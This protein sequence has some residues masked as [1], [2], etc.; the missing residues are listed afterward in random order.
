MR[1]GMLLTALLVGL[2]LL[3]ACELE[4]PAAAPVDAAPEPTV[5][6]TEL[7][8]GQADQPPESMSEAAPEPTSELETTQ[9]GLPAVLVTGAV[10]N[11]RAGP[12]TAHDV[13]TTVVQ[14]EALVPAGRNETG[15]WLY[16]ELP[17]QEQQQGWIY[18]NLT[19]FDPEVPVQLPV[20]A[21][22]PLPPPVPS[23]TP[24]PRPARR[25]DYVA[26]G[27]YDRDLP[28]LDYEWDLVFIDD[29][30][31]WDW[32]IPD[33]LGCYDA[34][35]VY[36][37][38]LARQFGL[39]RAE[40]SLADP[41]VDRDLTSWPLPDFTHAG[42]VFMQGDGD[43]DGASMESL[44]PD[45]AD[46]APHNLAHVRQVCTDWP[47]KLEDY[48]LGEYTCEV[49]PLWGN[50][51]H[52]VGRYY[53]NAA[54]AQ[55]MVRTLGSVLFADNFAGAKAWKESAWG[56]GVYLYPQEPFTHYPVGDGPCLRL[57]K[58]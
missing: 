30:S 48:D 37:G 4:V 38:P 41:P 46:S 36:L 5:E 55:V 20:V 49:Y 19:D 47:Y 18:A 50:T 33:R 1:K 13:L 52:E 53:L 54:G 2:L 27:T 9:S 17:E 34:M 23:P 25:V 28:G 14:G 3:S 29:S 31:Q 44:W 40:F 6:L 43:F 10:V 8:S 35:R 26:P 15:T 56:G 42:G 7:D 21:A 11:V 51:E 16:V 39:K 45:W 57:I 12:S 24:T 22:P 32:V 58:Q